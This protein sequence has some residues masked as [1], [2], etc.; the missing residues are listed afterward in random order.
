M[1]SYLKSTFRLLSLLVATT[2]FSAC[3]LQQAELPIETI[4]K[5]WR[6]ILAGAE[7]YWEEE[8]KMVIVASS[9]EI[10]LLN[11]YISPQARPDL[12]NTDFGAYFIVAVFQGRKRSGAGDYEVNIERIVHSGDTVK[13]YARFKDRTGQFENLAE[14]S[15]YHVVRVTK[16]AELAGKEVQFIL[17]ANDQE[18]VKEMHR[19][20]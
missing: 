15:P 17:I 13:V 11:P 3:I 16:P 20:P 5:E 8:P 2:L 1:K 9:D 10:S 7:P 4:E 6:G 18:I 14:S 19:F 12:S